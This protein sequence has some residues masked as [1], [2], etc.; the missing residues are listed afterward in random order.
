MQRI[1]VS[2]NIFLHEHVIIMATGN[3][4]RISQQ[5]LWQVHPASIESLRFQGALGLAESIVD[6]F[7]YLPNTIGLGRLSKKQA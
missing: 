5:P 3:L 1:A 4:T 6:R 2:F 7:R